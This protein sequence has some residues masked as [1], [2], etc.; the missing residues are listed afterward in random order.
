MSERNSSRRPRPWW[1]ALVCGMASYV[2][3]ASIIAF[4][5]AILGYQSLLGLDA[6]QVGLASGALTFGV[7]VGAILGGRLGDRFG[8]RPVFTLTMVINVVALVALMFAPSFEVILIAGLCLGLGTGADLPVSLASISEAATDANR[9]KLLGFSNLLW[10]AGAVVSSI[11]SSQV[12]ALGRLGLVITFGQIAFFALLTLA[13][14]LTIPESDDWIAARTERRSGITTIRA[15]RAGLGELLRARYLT[16]LLALIVFYSL[17]NLVA[18]TTGQY[19]T[20]VLVNYGGVDVA[21]AGVAGLALLPLSIAGYLWFMRIADKP[22]RYGYFLVGA[23]CMVAAPLVYA[24]FGVSLTTYLIQTF[25]QAVGTSFAFE[26]IMKVWTQESFP[27]LLRTTAQGTILAV[28]RFAAAALASVTPLLLQL[29]PNLMY[30]ILAVVSIVG[31]T[32]AAIV[33]RGRDRHNE[34]DIETQQDEPAAT[35]AA[36]A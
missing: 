12:A 23:V 34:F 14:R 30:A 25:F 7:A 24:V 8:R 32:T 2:D 22:V 5:I 21:I 36:G 6:L 3:A 19:G 29:G 13:G 11:V 18:N 4:G 26:G 20:Y 16:P 27:T 31:V 9:G 15:R 17:T 10:L 35:V 33:F 28:A 1:V